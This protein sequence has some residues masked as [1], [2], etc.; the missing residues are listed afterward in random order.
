MPKPAYRTAPIA[1]AELAHVAREARNAPPLG[2]AA[3]ERQCRAEYAAPMRAHLAQLAAAGWRIPAVVRRTALD[4]A[5]K[6]APQTEAQCAAC[7]A[8]AAALVA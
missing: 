8:F 7:L 2:S 5:G 1:P 6:E 3:D 4:L